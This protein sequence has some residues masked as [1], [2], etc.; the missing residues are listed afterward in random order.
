MFKARIIII[1]VTLC[2]AVFGNLMYRYTTPQDFEEKMLELKG[3]IRHLTPESDDFT[4]TNY[5]DIAFLYDILKEKR[6]VVLGEQTHFDAKTFT[7]KG[8]IIKYLHEKLGYDV[9]LYEAGLYDMWQMQIADSLNPSAGLYP[10]WWDNDENKDIWNYYRQRISAGDS[11]YFGGF[12][13]SIT[14][15]MEDSVRSKK[16]KTYLLSRNINP[17]DYQGLSLIKNQMRKYSME[18]YRGKL[19]QSQKEQILH[20]FQDIIEHLGNEEHSLEDEIY[21]R[22]L[23]NLKLRYESI[24]KHDAGEL[25]RMQLRDSL[26]ADNFIW[27]AD[28]VYNK[29]RI[30]VWTASL[31]ALYGEPDVSLK[32]FTSMGKRIKD[33]FGD[34][35]YTIT[36]SSYGRLNS[37]GSLMNRLGNKSLEYLIHRGNYAYAYIDFDSISPKSFLNEEFISGINQG[38]DIKARWSKRTD[39]MIYI[40]TMTSIK[41]AYR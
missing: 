38:L 21:R 25:P 2:M 33:H 10:F 16:L 1:I 7:M 32:G 41:P 12:D 8:R 34:S 24:W 31:H 37:E 9:V 17:E 28:T 20:D 19:T 18:Y 30:V 6:I 11:I 39:M 29:K 5:T 40:D 4:D 3:C 23:T 15:D 26:M 27:L 36:F 35:M 22:Y 13:I 14:G